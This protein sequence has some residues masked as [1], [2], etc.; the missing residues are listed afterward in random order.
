[1]AWSPGRW[2]HWRAIRASNP[3]QPQRSGES[4]GGGQFATW[5]AKKVSF[6][7]EFTGRK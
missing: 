3:D 5:A 2:H 4:S 6:A 7:N 1:V